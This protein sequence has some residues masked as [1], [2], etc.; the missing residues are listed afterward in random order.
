[1]G[2]QISYKLGEYKII[3][4]DVG[5]LFW[6][7]YGPRGRTETGRCIINDDILFIGP[8]EAEKAGPAKKQFI[9]KLASRP[10]WERTRYYCPKFALY[11]C[12]TGALCRGFSEWQIREESG[13]GRVAAD[14][15][16]YPGTGEIKPK[17]G[18]N[19]IPEL[20]LKSLFGLCKQ[21]L[22]VILLYAFELI[23]MLSKVIKRVITEWTKFRH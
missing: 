14:R 1:M 8:T 4:T 18:K 6:R 11:H 12:G 16:S 22:G 23:K 13:S 5:G 10:D 3:E 17:T 9:L 2:E 19:T 15:K 20:H 7:T 21:I